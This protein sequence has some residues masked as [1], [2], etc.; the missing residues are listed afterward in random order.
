MSVRLESIN[1]RVRDINAGGDVIIASDYGMN[2]EIHKQLADISTALIE[3]CERSAA[4]EQKSMES[5]EMLSRL[6]DRLAVP[7]EKLRSLLQK[8][9]QHGF[10]DDHLAAAILEALESDRELDHDLDRLIALASVENRKEIEAALKAARTKIDDGTVEEAEV[11][12]LGLHGR[13]LGDPESA[14]HWLVDICLV[15]AKI[16]REEFDIEGATDWYEQAVEALP[17]TARREQVTL[18]YDAACHLF[19]FGYYRGD[20]TALKRCIA[21]ADDIIETL[22]PS[23]RTQHQ[24]RRVRQL[25]SWTMKTLG[26]RLGNV[27]LLHEAATELQ[28]LAAETAA[29]GSSAEALEPK[30]LAASALH[31]VG[32]LE[33]NVVTLSYARDLLR[34]VR[35]ELN[36]LIE[37]SNESRLQQLRA[38]TLHELGDVHLHMAQ[39]EDTDI[40]RRDLQQARD[41]LIEVIH[42]YNQSNEKDLKAR[43][44][45]SLGLVYFALAET[46]DRES[47]AE[48]LDSAEDAYT[49]AVEHRSRGLAPVQWASTLTNRGNLHTKRGIL[50][51]DLSRIRRGRVDIDKALQVLTPE[52]APDSWA[53]AQN[54]RGNA[55][56]ALAAA[57]ESR[58]QLQEAV[59]AYEKASLIWTRDAAPLQH[60]LTLQN[61]ACALMRL[62]EARRLAGESDTEAALEVFC[63]AKDLFAQAHG[64]FVEAKALNYASRT[65]LHLA[66]VDETIKSAIGVA[67]A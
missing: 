64:T 59:K 40:G 5:D 34:G 41:I 52:N 12:V 35:A 14:G 51:R 57:D 26:Q 54:A 7:E 39:R 62:G 15:L 55:L 53:I 19:H 44:Q 45:N 38:A 63:E 13:L 16:A 36:E 61:R 43:A 48:Y 25:R 22:G 49:R 9:A 60:A 20:A 31:K 28:D 10:Q 29:S 23:P 67:T 33:K 11:E 24:Q 27:D 30:R 2:A 17:T 46:V 32:E 18:R 3:L 1:V 50:E 42:I 66:Q 21:L 37:G 47:A 56:S 4:K 6:G 8:G 58:E 65:E